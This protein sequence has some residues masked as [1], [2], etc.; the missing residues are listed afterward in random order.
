MLEMD[1][2]GCPVVKNPP[3]NTEDASLIP[4]LETKISYAAY[5]N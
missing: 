1:F 3:F 4:G 2:P 5:C